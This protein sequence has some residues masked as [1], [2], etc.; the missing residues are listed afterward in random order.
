MV[1][2]IIIFILLA[3]STQHIF[4]LGKSLEQPVAEFYLEAGE[5]LAGTWKNI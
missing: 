4:S 2:H 3:T 1:P 5:L